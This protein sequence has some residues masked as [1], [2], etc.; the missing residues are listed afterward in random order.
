MLLIETIGVI[1]QK[2]NSSHNSNNIHMSGNS[3]S[4]MSVKA[5][6]TYDMLRN[7]WIFPSDAEVNFTKPNKV[8]PEK[9]CTQK[10]EEVSFNTSPPVSP[11]EF[12]FMV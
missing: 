1:A 10:L 6:L 4:D 9:S 11:D 3:K 12:T 5:T 8:C 2:G 7:L